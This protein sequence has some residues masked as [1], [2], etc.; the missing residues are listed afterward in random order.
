MG[1]GK[2][3]LARDVAPRTARPFVDLDDEIE[4]ATGKTI[5]ALFADGEA[6]FR[7]V[8]EG[9]A[10]EVLARDQAVVAFGGG[11]L[12]SERTRAALRERALTV[13]VDVDVDAAWSRVRGGDRPLAQD[14]AAFRTLYEQRR[15]V[16]ENVADAT[17]R[18]AD[19]VVLAAAGIRVEQ[20]AYGALGGLSPVEAV[21][22]ARVLELHP[23]PLDCPTHPVESK[24]LVACER[25]WRTLRLE[26]GGTLVAI[27]G[28]TTTD[29][30]G[31]VAAT[32]MRGIDWV[33]VPTTLVGQVD[34]AIGGKTGIDLP[35]GK[36]LV[37]AF[38][39][40]RGTVIDPDFLGT[41]PETER[42][43]G[44]AEVVKTGLL[45]GDAL[46]ELPEPD[47]V[48]RC[49][50]FKAAVCLSDPHDHSYRAMLNLGHTFAHALEAASDYAVPHGEA[51]ALGLVAALGLSG[52]DDEARQVEE[53]LGP[54]RP[55]VDAGRAWEA[56]KRDK[57]AEGGLVK[58]VLL[59]APGKPLTAVTLP[60]A[61]VRRA[62]DS[63]IA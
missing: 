39:W 40:P 36:N 4:R 8:E 50:A 63:L 53:L 7:E 6:V 38:H 28:G 16:Y 20:G 49:A 34:A 26:R 25:L 32:Y 30:G 2:S 13:H 45:A 24:T 59:E 52:L 17:A 23:S 62:L 11:A 3:T 33:A 10:A 54:T 43:N 48:R 56:L 5:S 41:L 27:G 60:D 21:V 15:P 19:D 1:A 61:D 12:A 37:G 14:E 35:E 57:K 44:M 47:F 18:D 58:L 55:H 9:V 31:F 51:V 29:V 46:W 22:D 42:R